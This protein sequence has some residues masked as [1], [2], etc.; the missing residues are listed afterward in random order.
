MTK[1]YWNGKDKLTGLEEYALFKNELKHK[2]N[3]LSGSDENY[4]LISFQISEEVKDTTVKG[5]ADILS[6]KFLS[7]CRY[8]RNDHFF[9]AI[10]EDPEKAKKFKYELKNF[11]SETYPSTLVESKSKTLTGK[12]DTDNIDKL[13]EDLTTSETIAKKV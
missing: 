3:E 9:L 5:I 8:S 13:V 7:V 6:K 1:E 11:I 4:E 12:E 2:I 10:Y